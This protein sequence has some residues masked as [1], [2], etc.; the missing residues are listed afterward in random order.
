M[1]TRVGLFFSS[2]TDTAGCNGCGAGACRGNAINSGCSNCYTSGSAVGANDCCS[3][4]PAGWGSS[5]ACATYCNV[6]NS[7]GSCYYGNC[8]TECRSGCKGGFK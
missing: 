6:T 1:K 8:S 7:A 5:N 3:G 4:S 2:S